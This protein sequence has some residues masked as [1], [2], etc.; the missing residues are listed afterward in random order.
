MTINGRRKGL[1]AEQHVATWFREHVHPDSRRV[2]ATGW[3]SRSGAQ[4]DPGDVHA[5]GLCVQ[6][7]ALA[8]PL[9]GKL[10]ADVWDATT[11]QAASVDRRPLLLEK[12][13]GTADVGQWWLWLGSH[14]YIELV[15]GRP[16]WV[17]PHLIRVQL[18]ALTAE[19][20]YWAGTH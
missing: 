9:S 18:G 10:L 3:S 20:K 16:M 17:G 4:Q 13:A 8:K 2:V 5:P 1:T 12:R 11:R 14:F 19:L 7:K 6:V 15:A